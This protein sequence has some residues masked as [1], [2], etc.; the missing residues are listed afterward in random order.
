MTYK[1]VNR[2][3][4]TLAER[5]YL[6]AVISGLALTLKYFFKRKKFTRQYPEEPTIVPEG[7]RGMP[8][9]RT[10]RDG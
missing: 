4:L 2:P 6:P 8:S 1:T 10:T 5:L 7:Y 3:D 9:S